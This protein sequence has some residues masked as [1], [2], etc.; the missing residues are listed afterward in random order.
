MK[1]CGYRC[2]GCQNFQLY[3]DGEVS[4]GC[5]W[6]LSGNCIT[7][8]VVRSWGSQLIERSILEKSGVKFDE[9]GH[10]ITYEKYKYPSVLTLK[11][12]W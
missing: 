5:V 11:R 6:E 9:N 7:D 2:K 4:G 10:V 12:I 1:I 3:D 8:D